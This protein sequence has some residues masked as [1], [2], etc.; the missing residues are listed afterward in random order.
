MS[1][2]HLVDYNHFLARMFVALLRLRE[3]GSLIISSAQNEEKKLPIFLKLCLPSCWMNGMVMAVTYLLPNK[4][5]PLCPPASPIAG[6][7][8]YILA[9][10]PSVCVKVWA[11]YI[12]ELQLAAAVHAFRKLASRCNLCN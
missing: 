2:F 3:C 5:Q 7:L 12:I 1:D 11:G 10:W 9:N 4:Q 8:A 6:W